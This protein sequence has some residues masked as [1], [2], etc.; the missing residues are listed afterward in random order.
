VGDQRSTAQ[1]KTK[2]V[3]KTKSHAS[4]D[5]F[6]AFLDSTCE[7]QGPSASAGPP[8][9]RTPVPHQPVAKKRGLGAE[10]EATLKRRPIKTLMRGSNLL[11]PLSGLQEAGVQPS[12]VKV[13]INTSRKGSRHYNF[14]FGEPTH[15][16]SVTTHYYSYLQLFI[17]F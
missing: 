3:E 16:V 11:E 12:I 7:K 9:G 14:C 1:S 4:K 15:R 6:E 8:T 5:V 10:D 2:T 17:L 13:G